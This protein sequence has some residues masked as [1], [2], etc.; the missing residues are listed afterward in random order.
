[1]N[2]IYRTG[3]AS[4]VIQIITW[5]ID[6]YVLTIKYTG[7]LLILK[8][9]LWIEFAVQLIEGMFY[10]WMIRNFATIQN[11]TQY[12]YYDWVITTPTML[13]TYCMYL[14]YL[15]TITVPDKKS[16]TTENIPTKSFLEIIQENTPV[17][18]PIAVLNTLMLLFGYLAEIG[19]ISFEWGAV[20]G[21]LPFFAFF[22]L[23]YENYAK[24]TTVGKWTFVYFIAVWGF[25]GIASLFS[26][27]YKNITYNVLDLFSKNFFG[28]FLAVVLLLNRDTSK[29]L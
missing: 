23:I 17:L 9:L 5:F 16:T 26:Y 19:K 12:R 20:L 2:L 4:I 6:L 22:Y 28:V 27:K 29:N 10:F 21:F 15:K 24:F 18:V 1:M 7:P 25:Y 3:V 8:N 11:I 13:F 14:I